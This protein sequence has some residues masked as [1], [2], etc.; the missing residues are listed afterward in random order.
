MRAP[1]TYMGM[2][3]PG[4]LEMTTLWM[5]TRSDRFMPDARSAVRMRE[6]SRLAWVNTAGPNISLQSWS[7]SAPTA[8]CSSL[9]EFIPR[10]I[11]SSWSTGSSSCTGRAANMADTRLPPPA[12]SGRA[13][14]RARWR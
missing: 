5:V 3:G 8:S 10:W 6:S 7:M 11:S 4:M 12:S 2:G 14:R 1:A 13:R 9:A